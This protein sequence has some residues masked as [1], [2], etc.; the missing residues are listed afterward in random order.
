[1]LLDSWELSSEDCSYYEPTRDEIEWYAMQELWRSR[2]SALEGL[3]RNRSAEV[4]DLPGWLKACRQRAKL[5]DDSDWIS[6]MLE[7]A[8]GKGY[9]PRH[10]PS[11]AV[12]D[13]L[14]GMA[15][16]LPHCAD[17]N[18]IPM[19][20]ARKRA[21]LLI[22]AEFW[23]VRHPWDRYMVFHGPGRMTV[24]ELQATIRMMQ[25]KLSKLHD[26]E[27]LKELG[28]RFLLRITEVGSLTY[29]R[30]KSTG[31]KVEEASEPTARGLVRVRLYGHKGERW[32]AK[33]DL[34]VCEHRNERGERTYYPHINVLIHLS[35][36]R[37][38]NVPVEAG[39]APQAGSWQYFLA[40][41][42]AAWEWGFRECGGIE[43]IREAIKYCAKPADL[44]RLSQDELFDLAEALFKVR[45]A[46]PLGPL[47]AEIR[48]RR[49]NCLKLTRWRNTKTLKLEIR[50]KPDH[51]ASKKDRSKRTLEQA[52]AE[53]V[54]LETL[55]KL[56]RKEA[57]KR[58]W[59]GPE[60]S[61][62]FDDPPEPIG[63]PEPP[64]MRNRVFARLVCMSV[65]TPRVTP[66]VMVFNYG[67]TAADYAR[68]CSMPFVRPMLE[69]AG[70]DAAGVAAAMREGV[71][72]IK[73]HTSAVTVRTGP[74]PPFHPPPVT[75]VF[76]EIA[77]QIRA[78]IA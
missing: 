57:V 11:T 47:R 25:R 69:A 27:W 5:N 45:L 75:P 59:R 9:K 13:L 18:F 62:L 15:M 48:H 6:Y 14:T 19:T 21:K 73:V 78:K 61:R 52:K 39:E 31:E 20:A 23:H 71:A 55:A 74:P 22:A 3:I 36:G 4:I 10:A 16:D 50:V 44:R 28:I 56:Q 51:N 64:A 49:V 65:H 37:L 26:E 7:M 67:H 77:D 38:P 66:H 1:M 58:T 63:P 8:G 30:I 70:V 53:K 42:H 43:D 33:S 17:K 40:K 54:E 12:V 24:G 34:E 72:P 46:E 35:K 29:L 76:P 60:K 2:E 68:V 41:M 32:I